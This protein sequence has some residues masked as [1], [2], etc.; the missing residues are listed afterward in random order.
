MF[1]DLPPRL[2]TLWPQ[3]ESSLRVVGKYA[4]H[5]GLLFVSGDG[6]A[7][8]ACHLVAKS[9][10]WPTIE[11]TTPDF[12][13]AEFRARAYEPVM[14]HERQV[15]LFEPQDRLCILISNLDDRPR[16]VHSGIKGILERGRL[17]SIV[18]ATA[19]DESKLPSYLNGHLYVCH[20]KGAAKGSHHRDKEG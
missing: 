11:Y 10:A 13:E 20:K 7:L 18:L 14:Q 16:C 17:P 2:M 12:S 5:T 19:C 3:L 15:E 9:L 6:Q 8:E 1:E 4:N